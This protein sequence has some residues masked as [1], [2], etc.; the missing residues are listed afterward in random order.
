MG[1]PARR[2]AQQGPAGPQGNGDGPGLVDRALR[3]GAYLFMQFAIDLVY[4]DRNY[5]VKKV[6]RAVGPWRL[7]VCLSARSILELPGA[8]IACTQTQAGD[9]VAFTPATEA[10]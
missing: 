3:I 1:R 6:R 9:V 8:T 7:S 10:N 4:L 5:Q 2:H